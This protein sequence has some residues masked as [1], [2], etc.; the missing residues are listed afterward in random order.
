LSGSSRTVVAAAKDGRVCF[1]LLFLFRLWDCLWL[2]LCT[3]WYVWERLEKEADYLVSLYEKVKFATR[4][5]R[6]NRL[7]VSKYV[8]WKYK[9]ETNQTLQVT[10]SVNWDFIYHTAFFLARISKDGRI[11]IPKVN[12]SVLQDGRIDLTGFVLNVTLEPF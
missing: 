5:Q 3:S 10:V 11:V 2:R 7:Q 12:M 4:L 1:K 6:G 9:L 8:R